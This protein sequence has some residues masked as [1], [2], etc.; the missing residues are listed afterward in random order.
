MSLQKPDKRT[1]IFED[2]KL[3]VCLASL[4][5]TAGHTIV[6]WKDNVKDLNMLNKSDYEHLMEAVDTT[7]GIMQKVLDVEKVYLL[8]MD[9]AQHVH[10][11]LVP[12]YKDEGVNLIA[13]K[14]KNL[15]IIALLIN[16]SLDGH[17]KYNFHHHPEPNN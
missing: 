17:N 14:P 10:W 7:R 6:A 3:Y 5:I 9:E 1:I 16:S 11:Q 15:Q 4:P 12:R 2:D 13:H 8:Y